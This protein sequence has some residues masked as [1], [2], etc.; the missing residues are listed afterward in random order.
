MQAS[1]GTLSTT[2]QSRFEYRVCNLRRR[3]DR[4]EANTNGTTKRSDERS[5][6]TVNIQSR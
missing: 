3:I 5:E 1:T 2:D 4:I 6:A